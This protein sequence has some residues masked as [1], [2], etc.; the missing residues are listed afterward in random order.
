M[1]RP[2]L[3]DQLRGRA[4]QLSVGILT[5]NWMS[6]GSE[7]AL[8]EREDVGLVHFD[9]MDGCFCPMTTIGASV[10]AGLKTS[11]LK[12]VHLMIEEPLNKVSTFVAA[13]ADIVTIH[14]E[15]TA[16]VYRALQSL[17][18]MANVNDPGRGIIRGLA[19]NPGTPVH[20]IEPL[21]DELD[22]V[23]VLAVN[24]GFGGQTFLAGTAE[25][26]RQVRLMTGGDVLICVDGGVTRDNIGEIGRMDA[27]IV[28]TGSAVFDGKSPADNLHSMMRSLL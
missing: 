21:L 7:L 12:D 27:D 6:L 15:R 11:M 2:P 10:V 23:L 8:L 18:Q 5:A 22:M 4:P 19:L 3:F 1:P 13:G 14:G 25:R 28:V 16:H 17:G 24:P 20:S 26:V 9:V